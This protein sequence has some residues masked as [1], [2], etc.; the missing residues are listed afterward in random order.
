MPARSDPFGQMWKE[1]AY[2]DSRYMSSDAFVLCMETSTAVSVSDSLA[3][4]P[5][6]HIASQIFWGPLCYTVAGMMIT[7]HPL[8]HPLQALVSLG[9]IYGLVLYYST[10]LFDDRFKGVTYFRPEAYYF[11]AYYFFLNF[12]W[13]VIPGSKLDI[14]PI[15]PC[16]AWVPQRLICFL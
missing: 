16:G 15:Q 13:L 6:L 14:S 11:W 5:Y 7:N 9:Q 3:K 8:R 4:D 2:S 10:S 1:Y 12:I